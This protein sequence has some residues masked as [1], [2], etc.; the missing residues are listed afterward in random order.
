MAAMRGVL[1][2]LGGWND[3]SIDFSE[4]MGESLVRNE[5]PRIWNPMLKW[6]KRKVFF[7]KMDGK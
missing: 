6:R 2:Q 4:I 3:L 1:F 5:A 7:K